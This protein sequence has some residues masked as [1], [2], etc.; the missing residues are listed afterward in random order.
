MDNKHSQLHIPPHN[1]EAE[2]ALL[3]A[4]L[5]D[6]E[7]IIK[8]AD[9]LRPDNFYKEAHQNIYSIILDLY[10]E[11]EPIDL[12]SLSNRLEEKG[13]LERI[14]GRSFLAGLAEKVPTAANITSY[15]KIIREKSSRRDLMQSSIKIAQ[16]A[17]QEIDVDQILD[18]AEQE[19]FKVT[20]RFLQ[21]NFIIIKDVLADT[22]ERIDDLHKN[23]GKLRGVPTGFA[24]MDKKLAGLQKT[25]LIILAARPAMGKTSLALDIA[26]N[27]AKQNVPVALFSLEMGKEQLVDRMLCA[28]AGIDLWK[29][30]TGKLSDREDDDDFPRLGHAMGVL[31]E[32]PLYIDDSAGCNVMEIRTKCRRLQAEHGLG[33]VIIDYLQLMEGSSAYSENRVQE[34][35][36]IS[37]GLK[38]LARELNV[39]VV[40]LSQL[41]RS[42]EAEH[43]PIPKLSHL[44]ESGAIEQDADIVM[45]VYREEYYNKD[46]T[47]KNVA[48]IIIAKHRNGPTGSFELLFEQ[49]KASFRNLDRD[50][51][52]L[53]QS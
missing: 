25:D 50:H 17:N 21:N 32:V 44:R 4:L 39:P 53:P 6:N 8:I 34:I 13:Q 1:I 26:R 20:Q 47:R 52:D 51:I 41:S 31:S 11:H 14:G 18:N 9:T 27:A 35:S 2:E 45:F 22:F 46:S 49:T 38:Q 24:D 5:I 29:L 16:I 7:G 42:V 37:R 15:S 28:E 19:L 23:A 10:R 43:P 33:L 3:G 48:D 12:L 36:K 40:A 30:R